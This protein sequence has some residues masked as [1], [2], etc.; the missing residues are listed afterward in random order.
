MDNAKQKPKN[1]W[2]Y[3]NSAK[4]TRYVLTSLCEAPTEA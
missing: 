2:S 1:D 4:D 3:S